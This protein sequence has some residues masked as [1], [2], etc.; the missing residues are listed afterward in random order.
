MKGATTT[1]T[2][3]TSTRRTTT[4]KQWRYIDGTTGTRRGTMRMIRTETTVTTQMALMMQMGRVGAT[5]REP[6]SFV[7][8]F[9]TSEGIY[10]IYSKFNVQQGLENKCANSDE[11]S[12]IIISQS[13]LRWSLNVPRTAGGR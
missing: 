1:T 8:I 3:S 13:L 2:T 9:V 11:L 4:I 10:L 12:T 7:V 5:G 6:L